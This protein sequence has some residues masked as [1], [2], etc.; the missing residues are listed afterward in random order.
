MTAPGAA[1][2]RSVAVR[3]AGIGLPAAAV[4]GALLARAALRLR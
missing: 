2:R 3:L 4:I 1:S